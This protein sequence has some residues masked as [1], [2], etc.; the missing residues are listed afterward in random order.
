[1]IHWKRWATLIGFA[2]V[3]LTACSAGPPADNSASGSTLLGESTAE[4]TEPDEESAP[5]SDTPTYIGTVPAPEFPDGL[6]WINVS[7]PLTIEDLRGKVVLMDFWTYGCINCIHM[8]PVLQQLEEKYGDE[9]VVI[10]VHSAKFATEGDTQNIRQIVQRYGLH[11]PVINDDEFKVWQIY[12]AQA[13]PTF[14]LIDPRGN[15]LASDAGE[16]P[17]DAFDNL[18]GNVVST[19]DELG[20]IDRTPLDIDLEGA[21]DPNTPLR[22]PGKVLADSESGRLFIADSN[23]HRIVVADLDT[24]EVLDVIGSG[25]CGFTDG[26]FNEAQF[27]QPQGMALDG[28]ILYVADTYNHAIRAVDLDA[29]TVTTIAGTGQRGHGRDVPT[30]GSSI[31]DPL[32]FNLRS[33][34]DVELDGKG[35]LYIAM[36]GL[37]QLW[38]YD[39]NDK[40]LR[41]AVG[42]GREALV[43]RTLS[44]SELAQPSGLYYTDGLLY[45]ADSE[46]SSIRVADIPADEVR[47]LSGP[48]GNTLFDFGDIDGELGTARLQHPL[49]VTGT[50]DG[51][52][53]IA[54]TYNSRIKRIDPSTQVTT[55]VFGLG[56]DGGFSDGDANTAQFDEPG[57]LDYANGKLYV[58][59]TNNHAIR[60][61]DLEAGTVSTVAFPN[62]EALVIENAPVTVVGGNQ[63]LDAD[64]TLDTQTVAS[65]SDQI[66]LTV[67]LPENFKINDLVD[68]TVVF[69]G[70]GDVTVEDGS[71]TLVIADDA[72]S[73]SLPVTVSGDG[74]LFADLTLYYCREGEEALCFIDTLVIEAPFTVE[75]GGA[76]ALTIEHTIVPPEGI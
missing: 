74:S 65:G 57:G 41:V 61:I 25:Q 46:S 50:P 34:W 30:D 51:T 60:V 14:V 26:A 10:G 6:E 54:D 24:Y 13:W 62:P 68:S 16:I 18:I 35:T 63:M 20:E 3:T 21:G 64:L 59:D 58:A 11:H 19:F 45:F 23:H 40:T 42:D 70:S 52:L 8:I 4:P 17:Y 36:A 66:T 9:L 33:P 49:G 55:T 47:L 28:S 29:G 7:A 27:N 56:G 75:D 39:L 71:Q 67:T 22:F 12:G 31:D 44:T 76:S 53:Y 32:N 69:S 37:H 38:A 1:M 43:N 48:T 72:R 15:V 73:V 2:A 5:A